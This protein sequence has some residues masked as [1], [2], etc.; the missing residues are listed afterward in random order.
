MPPDAAAFVAQL[1]SQ[2]RWS[3][4]ARERASLRRSLLAEPQ[5]LKDWVI[6]HPT[7]LKRAEFDATRQTLMWGLI[8]DQGEVLT[9]EVAY[10]EFTAPALER[11]EQLATDEDL[12]VVARLR[13]GCSRFVAEP[14]SL[15]RVKAAGDARAVDS[16][17]FDAAPKS[18]FASRLLSRLRRRPPEVAE[19]LRKATSAVPPL[20]A[21]LRQFLRLQAERGLPGDAVAGVRDELTG[22]LARLSAAGFSVFESVA[23]G[24]GLDTSS[25]LLRAQY[26]C[27]QY[28]HLLDDSA[29]P[30]A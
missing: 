27:M 21:D 28:E 25:D 14:L 13:G 15:I 26:L 6:L 1:P 19:T 2:S 3:E 24:D 12:M 30:L 22:R 8:D 23:G 29:E 4:V 9:A 16:L 10:D 18:G 20:L 11:I 17:Y 5:P 7:K